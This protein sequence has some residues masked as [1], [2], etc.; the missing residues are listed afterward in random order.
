LGE[1]EAVD[2][3]RVGVGAGIAT[4]TLRGR[5]YVSPPPR[6]DPRLRVSVGS[7]RRAATAVAVAVAGG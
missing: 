4:G 5:M 7:V 2:G 3:R 1:A 6:R